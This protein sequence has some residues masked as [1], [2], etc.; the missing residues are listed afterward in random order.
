MLICEVW[1]FHLRTEETSVGQ[2]GRKHCFIFRFYLKTISGRNKIHRVSENWEQFYKILSS[3]LIPRI[4][5]DPYCLGACF[6]F[7]YGR[8][9][10]SNNSDCQ[11]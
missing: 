2:T 9:S 5:I 10:D 6:M 8:G 7:A 3:N 1:N 4:C 11:I